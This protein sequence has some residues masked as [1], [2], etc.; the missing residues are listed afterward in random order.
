MLPKAAPITCTNCGGVEVIYLAA[1]PRHGGV[2]CYCGP[3]TEPCTHCR[4][5]PGF[6][7]CHYC[8]EV[9]TEYN[10]NEMLCHAH[11]GHTDPQHTSTERT[12]T[13]WEQR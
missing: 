10:D 3:H 5:N 1:C 9:A 2:R 12:L 8:K 7:T 11:A 6:E 4:T 13:R